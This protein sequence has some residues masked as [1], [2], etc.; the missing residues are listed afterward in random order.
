MIDRSAF[1]GENAR[2]SDLVRSVGTKAVHRFGGKAD[3]ATLPQHP[4]RA[5]Y[6]VAAV[7]RTRAEFV[8][9]GSA[10]RNSSAASKNP[11]FSVVAK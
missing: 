9:V 4:H 8:H 2:D 1:R 6:I 3:D 10:P 7:D 11:K 5:A